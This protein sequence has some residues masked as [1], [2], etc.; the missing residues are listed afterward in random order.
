[1]N[2]ET[3]DALCVFIVASIAFAALMLMPETYDL[4]CNIGAN[5]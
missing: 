4:I 2:Q 1:M 5:L 3:K